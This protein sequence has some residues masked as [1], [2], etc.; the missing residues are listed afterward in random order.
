MTSNLFHA[1]RAGSNLPIVF[2]HGFGGNHEIWQSL[3]DQ[4]DIPNRCLLYDLPGHAGSLEFPGN[5]SP[6]RAGEAIL[7]DLEA[8]KIE[9]IHLVGHSMG[10]AICCLI[11]MAAP[12]RVASLT[13][14]APGGFGPEI[15]ADVLR[16]FAISTSE[17]ELRD[18]L[19]TMG[20][21]NHEPDTAS[22]EALCKQRAK[23]GQTE[24]LREIAAVITRDGKQGALPRA[25]MENFDFPVSIVWGTVDN[26][27]PFSQTNDLPSNFQFFPVDGAGHMLPEE[28]PEIVAD[29][30]RQTVSA[31]LT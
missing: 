30:I 8:Q 25:N 31:K 19:K 10:G 16:R 27:L 15:N 7:A 20:G 9:K 12:D 11:A 28:V 18:S 24:K 29:V 21:P 3:L 6:R 22:L 23:P 26:V 1:E 13:L 4:F 17:D 14:V 5:F 2:L